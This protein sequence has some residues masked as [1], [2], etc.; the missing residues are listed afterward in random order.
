M[1]GKSE[2]FLLFPYSC[3]IFDLGIQFGEIYRPRCN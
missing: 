2:I 3:A 1:K